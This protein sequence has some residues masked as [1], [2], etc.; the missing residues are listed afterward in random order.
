MRRPM[1]LLVLCLTALLVV[2]AMVST[3][4]TEKAAT[5]KAPMA[6]KSVGEVVSVDAT[7]KTLSIKET[8]KKGDT[9]E[10]SFTIA[11]TAK[12]MVQGKAGS[13]SDLKPGDSVTVKHM[14]KDGKDTVEEITVMKPMSKHAHAAPKPAATATSSKK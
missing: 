1:V 9:K 8:L 6:H 12:V 14:M 13:L 10:M 11:D 5:H 4:A 3:V 2:G 7:A